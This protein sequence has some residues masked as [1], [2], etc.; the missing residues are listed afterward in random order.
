MQ[1]VLYRGEASLPESISGL[2][3]S[4]RYIATAQSSGVIELFSN[5][6]L[7]SLARI[8]IG[9]RDIQT[10]EFNGDVLVIGSLTQGI[11]YVDTLTM[12]VKKEKKKESGKCCAGK[13][14]SWLFTV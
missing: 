11:A 3:V 7:F 1:L 2:A 4:N 12:A 10:M 13:N 8:D 14:R 9:M 5:P 6:H